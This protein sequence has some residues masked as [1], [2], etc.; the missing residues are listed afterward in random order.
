MSYT[1]FS[2]SEL[3][4]TLAEHLEVS[5]RVKNVGDRGGLETVQVYATCEACKERRLAIML[6]GF[7]KVALEALESK[8]VRLQVDLRDLAIYSSEWMLE[9]SSYQ[10]LV[11]PAAQR[12]LLLTQEIELPSRR[13]PYAPRAPE[14]VEECRCVP[15]E[16]AQHIEGL[17][18]PDRYPDL[19]ILFSYLRWYRKRLLLLAL[20]LLLLLIRWCRRCFKRK[21]S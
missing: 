12:D 4:V 21:Q 18:L 13:F 3:E 14:A 16:A 9:P 6:V 8:Q 7:K 17:T 15:E 19:L 10:I 2:Y 20:V 11:G 1:K 5:V